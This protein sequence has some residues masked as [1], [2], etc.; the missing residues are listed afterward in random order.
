MKNFTNFFVV[1]M[2]TF[3]C[4]QLHAQ[5]FGIK[6][7]L[8]LASMLAKDDDDTYSDEF[9]MNPGFHIGPT[10]EVPVNDVV[11]FDTGVLLSTK[12]FKSS[13]EET[14]MGETYEYTEKAII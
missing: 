10:M 4:L 2:A 7:G 5:T 13:E 14:Y 3:F 8:S 12:G 1:L 11:S 6:G 9:K